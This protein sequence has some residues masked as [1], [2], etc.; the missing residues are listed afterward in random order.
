MGFNWI[1]SVF[2]LINFGIVVG[3][4]I[5]LF[6]TKILKQIREKIQ[7]QKLFVQNLQNNQLGYIKQREEVEIAMAKQ[8][9]YA[10]QLIKKI[11]QWHDHAMHDFMHAQ[12]TQ[13]ETIKKIEQRHQNQAHYA[14]LEQSA[15]MII[16]PT[17][18][19]LYKN[20]VQLFKDQQK[21]HAYAEKSIQQFVKE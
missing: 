11:E 8:A 9:E 15:Q 17:L 14:Q 1:N 5:Y 20:A 13:E 16:Q 6:Y 19:Q 3:A 7:E 18:E 21:A 10:Q 4:T 2:D 12:H